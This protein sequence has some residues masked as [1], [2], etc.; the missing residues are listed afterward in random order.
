[1]NG[2]H[3]AS[4]LWLKSELKK[5]KADGKQVIVLTHHAPTNVYC[6]SDIA[7]ENKIGFSMNFSS[8]EYFFRESVI[9][10][11]FFGH[12]H[13]NCDFFVQKNRNS[14]DLI[15][16]ATNQM[17]YLPMKRMAPDYV[18]CKCIIFPND[19]IRNDDVPVL[20][21]AELK[22]KMVDK[23]DFQPKNYFDSKIVDSNA[24]TKRY[25]NR[26]CGLCSK[27]NCK[28]KC[29]HTCVVL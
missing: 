23:N 9:I 22:K 15:R 24:A 7:K 1:M 5:A 6:V 16:I 13:Y 11:W 18:D 10:G 14:N 12:T 2:F 25:M 3:D 28:G 29:C 26:K 19:D 27:C 17:G 20:T 4:I 8:L 21:F